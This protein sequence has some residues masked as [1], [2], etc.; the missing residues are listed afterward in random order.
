MVWKPAAT[1][2]AL[3]SAGESDAA[4]RRAKIRITTELAGGG[5]ANQ[6]RQNNKRR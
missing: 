3:V 4:K 1:P 5:E 2:R 6:D